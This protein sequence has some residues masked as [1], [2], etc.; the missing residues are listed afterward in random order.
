MAGIPKSRRRGKQ[1]LAV[2]RL[3][4][5]RE[6]YPFVWA[7][8]EI[9]ISVPAL[10]A[11]IEKDSHLRNATAYHQGRRM[12]VWPDL[13]K[14]YLKHQPRRKREDSESAEDMSYRQA[15]T[16]KQIIAAELMKM[17]LEEKAG[18]YIPKEVVLS[19]WLN[20]ANVVKTAMLAIPD[21]LAPLLAVETD[22]DKVYDKLSSEIKLVLRNLEWSDGS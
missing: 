13:K 4:D 5:G 14:E 11:A 2:I 1:K 19:Q 17:E 3:E 15:S 16:Q 21:R 10:L 9:G 7:A 22:I 6:L 20:I 18:K 8:R 12:A